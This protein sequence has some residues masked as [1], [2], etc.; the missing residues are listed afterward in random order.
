MADVGRT[1]DRNVAFPGTGGFSLTFFLHS[2]YPVLTTRGIVHGKVRSMKALLLS[3]LLVISQSIL[4]AGNEESAD[5]VVHEW[6]TFTSLQGGDGEQIHWKPGIGVDLPKF[7]YLY[8]DSAGNEAAAQSA[9]LFTKRVQY[10]KQRMET[11][12]LYFYSDNDLAVDV[13]VD[14]PNGLHTEWYP[15]VS[16]M[17]PRVGVK[18]GKVPGPEQADARRSFIRWDD[19]RVLAKNS[20]AESAALDGMLTSNE[21]S[22]YFAARQTDANMIQFISEK[23]GVS[24]SEYDRFLFYRGLGFFDSPLNVTVGSTEKKLYVRNTGTAP[25]K[26]LYLLEVRNGHGS[27]QFLDALQ[28]GVRH[29]FNRDPNAKMEPLENFTSN[30]FDQLVT[31]L[32]NSGL[33]RE[34]ARAMVNTWRNSWFGEDG[35]RVLYVLPEQWTDDTLPL[36][37]NPKPRELKRVMVGRAEVILPS[38]EWQ[39]TRSIVHFSDG[40]PALRKQA[41]ADLNAL[42]LGRFLEPFMRKATQWNSN[43]PF[44][45]HAQ[46]LLKV[47]RTDA[48]IDASTAQPLVFAGSPP[49]E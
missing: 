2:T 49:A 48:P 19:V 44:R 24:K 16:A 46:N 30:V 22:H 38:I 36:Q 9:G 3:T 34:E 35:I 21:P 11:P 12:V 47:T 18:S 1:G 40:D 39:I 4:T 31:S 25:I 14:F 45:I 13:S 15:R 32:T 7:V 5:Y 20:D 17:G 28:P 23:E 6:G 8:L 42:R 41:I 33:Y 27:F 43:Q 26:H 29:Q 37:L 10:A